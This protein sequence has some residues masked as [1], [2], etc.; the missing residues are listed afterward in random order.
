MMATMTAMQGPWATCTAPPLP[1]P[2]ACPP[3]PAAPKFKHFGDFVEDQY[4]F[5]H[6]CMRKATLRA[7]CDML[8]MAD[9]LQAHGFYNK[10]GRPA[11]L[12]GGGGGGCGCGCG[13]GG[14]G[15]ACAPRCT[16]RALAAGVLDCVWAVRLLGG[17]LAPPACLPLTHPLKPRPSPPSHPHPP[18]RPRGPP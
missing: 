5:H 6:Y 17:G 13:C 2:A 10:V 11:L 1:T 8:T 3:T 12:A 15:A 14:G 16:G 9:G 7:Y 4:D 18:P